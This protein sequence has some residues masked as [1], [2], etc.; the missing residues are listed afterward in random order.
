MF[1]SRMS[2]LCRRDHYID[3]ILFYFFCY[4]RSITGGGGLEG[5]VVSG[6]GR[7]TERMR[8]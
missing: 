4:E 3:F 6:N 5:G 1:Y 2:D 7:E 8:E